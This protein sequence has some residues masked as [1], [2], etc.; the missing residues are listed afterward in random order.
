MIFADLYTDLLE[1]IN[2]P[3]SDGLVPVKREINKTLMQLQRRTQ[4][5]YAERLVRFTY[6]AGADMIN[7]VDVC[8]GLPRDFISLQQL[9]KPDAAAGQHIDFMSYGYLYNQR[10]NWNRTQTT[11]DL[12]YAPIRSPALDESTH[13]EWVGNVHSHYAFV[14]NKQIGL[15]PRP[16]T[17]VHLLLNL[18]IWLPQLVHDVDTNFLLDYCYDCVHVLSLRKLQLFYKVDSRW[19][20]SDAEVQ[21][22]WADVQAWNGTVA[23]NI[24]T[25]N[26]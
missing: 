6:P 11:P 7:L 10:R 19:K 3:A 24:Q 21:E 16:T 4:F 13:G 25:T 9:S 17:D 15:Y 5:K 14:L 8:D 20:V 1:T 22:A 2:R 26:A 23:T 18:H 12:E